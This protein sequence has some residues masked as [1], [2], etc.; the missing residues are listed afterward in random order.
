MQKQLLPF[1]DLPF[2]LWS[3]SYR[4]LPFNMVVRTLRVPVRPRRIWRY[5]L[6]ALVRGDRGLEEG[7][8]CVCSHA[9]PAHRGIEPLYYALRRSACGSNASLSR[10]PASCPQRWLRTRHAPH[11][12]FTVIAYERDDL[13]RLVGVQHNQRKMVDAIDMSEVLG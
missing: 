1:L 12:G 5:P 3:M 13:F 11:R 9:L 2:P 7:S 8:A 4:Q 10:V 6:D